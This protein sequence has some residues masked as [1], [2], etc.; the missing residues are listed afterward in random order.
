MSDGQRQSRDENDD[1]IDGASSDD[2]SSASD[3]HDNALTEF[4]KIVRN[5]REKECLRLGCKFINSNNNNISVDEALTILKIV[6]HG[7][8]RTE[9]RGPGPVLFRT[10]NSELIQGSHVKDSTEDGDEFYSSFNCY[11]EVMSKTSPEFRLTHERYGSDVNGVQTQ[12][13]I[14]TETFVEDYIER[15][16]RDI[17]SKQANS[18]AWHS[19]RES[20]FNIMDG[21]ENG[22]YKLES[23]R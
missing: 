2:N 23:Q 16:T 15:Q 10:E 21:A 11:L 14:R 1:H 3:N 17:Y 13:Q 8:S 7:S 9:A 18:S 22:S 5:S 6:N 12:A 4:L 20:H 19:N